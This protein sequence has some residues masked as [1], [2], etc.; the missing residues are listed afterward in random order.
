M[1]DSY[2][3]IRASRYRPFEGRRRISVTPG[4]AQKSIMEPDIWNVSYENLL[5]TVMPAE[6]R[7]FGYADDG[8]ALIAT[9]HVQ[10]A[11]LRMEMV[12][13]RVKWWTRDHGL[14]LALG[15]A[16]IVVLRKKHIQTVTSMRVGQHDIETS[17]QQSIGVIIYSV[18]EQI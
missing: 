11:Q 3:K 7:L 14:S 17:L 8:I 16:E 12:M 1:I 18:G 5:I 13:R 2:L 10:K 6:T 9:G 15:K 4:A